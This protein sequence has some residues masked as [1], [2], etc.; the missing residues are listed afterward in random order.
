MIFQCDILVG[1]SK[2]N[3]L[4]RLKLDLSLRPYRDLSIKGSHI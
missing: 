1:T 3:T 2:G 4:Q